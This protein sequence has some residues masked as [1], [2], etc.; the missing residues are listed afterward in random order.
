MYCAH[1]AYCEPVSKLSR[2]LWWR[3]GKRN[4]S[5]PLCLWDL[6]SASNSP[7][8]PRRLSCQIFANQPK[9]GTRQ[10]ECKQTLKNM[11]KHVPRVVTSLLMSSPPISILGR[12]FQHRYSNS[13][14]VVESSP[15]LSPCRQSVPESLL[16][17]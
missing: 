9:A 11:F 1:P 14:D 5:L 12:L 16:A 8:A 7:V 2:A 15:S 13:R 17:G 3:G 6:N 10:S 4:E